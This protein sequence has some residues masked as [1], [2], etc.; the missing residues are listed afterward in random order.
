MTVQEYGQ[1]NT[2]NTRNTENFPADFESSHENI[3][4][5]G[6]LSQ[7]IF[8]Y[9]FKASNPPRQLYCSADVWLTVHRNSVWIR[10]TN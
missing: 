2:V 10:K 6:P 1:A 3:C 5:K 4:G 8:K 7:C 9:K